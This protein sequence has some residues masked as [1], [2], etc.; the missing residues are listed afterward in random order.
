[1]GISRTSLGAMALGCVAL[2]AAC[3][4]TETPT[5]PA[6]GGSPASGGTPTGGAITG[7]AA[8]GGKAAGGSATGGSATGGSAGGGGGAAPSTG[9][10]KPAGLT[11]GRASIDVSGKT[12]EYILA[13]PS[14]YNQN[15]PYRL[16]F[17]WH[18][19]GGSAQQTASMGYFG[20]SSVINGQAILVAPEGQNYQDAGLGW[21]N[22]NGEDL[23]FMHAMVDRFSAQLC[24]D[25]DRIFSTGF[26]IGAMF[27]FTLGCSQNGLM[28]A[29]A[30][31]AGNA[32]TSGRCESGTRSVA[33]MAFIGTDDT[34]LSGHRQA[35]QIFVQRNGCTTDK[36]TM[37]PSWCDGLASNYLPCTCWQYQGCKPGY[38]VIECEYKAG[39]MFAPSSGATL[40][41]FFSQF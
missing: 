41:Q 37:T 12:R 39:H 23:D 26:S 16:I 35:V 2:A 11:N 27:S 19:W 7:G 36:V 38:P 31:Q 15:Q 40:W 13:I 17:G 32:T 1:M 6:T 8:S 30:P 9:C 25:Q 3:N 22:A 14:N 29:I 24:I 10:G 20:L 33:T 34:L 18:P 4:G 28:R 21:G 5:D